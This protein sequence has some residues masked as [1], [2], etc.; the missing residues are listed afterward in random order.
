MSRSDWVSDIAAIGIAIL[1]AVGL[2]FAVHTGSGH[3]PYGRDNQSSETYKGSHNKCRATLRALGYRV[4]GITEHHE[5]SPSQQRDYA[6]L[7]QQV[8]MAQAAEES[9]EAVWLQFWATIVSLALLALTTVAA[10]YAAFYARGAVKEGRRAADAAEDSVVEGRRAAD[11]A[12]KGAL[13]A[14]TA[15]ETARSATEIELRAYLVIDKIQVA[16]D[17]IRGA[18]VQQYAGEIH[19][20]NIGKTHA[21]NIVIFFRFSSPTPGH[22]IGRDTPHEEWNAMVRIEHVS[23]GRSRTGNIMF[24][25]PDQFDFPG[26]ARWPFQCTVTV[27]YTDVF[28]KTNGEHIE[29]HRFGGLLGEWSFKP[30]QSPW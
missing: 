10:G 12:A 13:A 25:I 19:I 27:A 20:S 4:P 26:Q 7:C 6:D 24:K 9:A 28:R 15:A 14:I 8:R 3:A 11:E 23:S 17:P 16:R 2:A 22:P 1:L 29:E 30:V 21:E 5:T 18:G